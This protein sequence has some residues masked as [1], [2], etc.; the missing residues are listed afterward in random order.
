MRRDMRS[1]LIRSLIAADLLLVSACSPTTRHF[2]HALGEGDAVI[3][4]SGADD[5]STASA[6][7]TYADARGVAEVSQPT[8]ALTAI[9]V[10]ERGDVLDLEGAPLALEGLSADLGGDRDGACG[11]RVPP[12]DRTQRIAPGDRCAI[13]AAADLGLSGVSL[14]PSASETILAR[15]RSALR[16]Q[17]PGA[18]ACRH[19]ALAAGASLEVCPLGVDAERMAPMHTVIATDGTI[20]AVSRMR[21]VEIAP[22][23]TRTETPIVPAVGAIDGLVALPHGGV[24]I[25]GDLFP[26]SA[27]DD[28]T[29][30][31]HVP[32][33]GSGPA[34]RLG[35]LPQ[36]YNLAGAYHSPRTGD[37]WLHGRTRN[38]LGFRPLLARCHFG[39]DVDAS[40]C[41]E[42]SFPQSAQCQQYQTSGKVTG[43]TELDDGDMVGIF[44]S[45][46]LV[47]SR[48][49]HVLCLP[50]TASLVAPRLG[51]GEIRDFEGQTLVSRGRR[52]LACV[53]SKR[54]E[55]AAVVATTLGPLVDGTSPNIVWSTVYEDTGSRSPDCP[56]GS[57][58]DPFDPS[59]VI[60]AAPS[61]AGEPKYVRVALTST[62]VDVIH[63]R[64]YFPELDAPSLDVATTSLAFALTATTG[65]SWVR[66]PGEPE[67][68]RVTR[69]HRALG[70]APRAILPLDD[71]FRV[72]TGAAAS[73][74]VHTGATCADAAL[75]IPAAALGAPG[76]D[77]DDAVARLGARILLFGHRGHASVM[78]VRD[79]ADQTVG[80]IP[81]EGEA[82]VTAAAEII[83]GKWAALIRDDGSLWIT[84]GQVVS[85]LGDPSDWHT[86]SAMPGVGWLASDLEIGRI[87]ATKGGGLSLE[88]NLVG[89]ID[90]SA[91]DA[92]MRDAQPRITAIHALC[93]G[94]AIVAFTDELTE[95]AET[96]AIYHHWTV[97]LLGPVSGRLTLTR[98]APF[99]P[100]SSRPLGGQDIAA[101][102][103]DG[104]APVLLFSS[105]DVHDLRGVGLHAPG[106]ISSALPLNGF[107][108]I[109]EQGSN[110]LVG[111]EYLRMSLVRRTPIGGP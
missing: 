78:I 18:C 20:T 92:L 100:P 79:S 37:T 7:V 34:R 101:I 36:K 22:D 89:D 30:Y 41:V 107:S 77:T 45:S 50:E 55:A 29:E 1:A 91:F 96:T 104:V 11:C 93:D 82:T 35:G 94:R 26:V 43:L 62:A 4:V 48:D 3:V 83:P 87:V 9:A 6:R 23:G 88:R 111:D 86:L 38:G 56:R 81:L 15:V 64:D 61:T 76:G 80:T 8:D 12:L 70:H 2:A 106:V 47:V 97:W 44:E 57:F 72:Y 40:S 65:E 28:R 66:R 90:A 85:T 63:Q 27:G 24:V 10:I 31:V 5:L 16:I 42:L 14:D 108:T 103:G 52:V 39:D 46:G 102:G 49:D 99:T 73:I 54:A 51:N 19:D 53:S 13:P 69:F 67:A 105:R 95:T 68:H 110:L 60:M 74:R 84:D 71:G 58:V 75:D 98:Y 17:W 33:R 32:R 21:V 59:H 109:A 25:M